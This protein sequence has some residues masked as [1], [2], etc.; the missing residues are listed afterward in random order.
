[1]RPKRPTTHRRYARLTA[2][3][4]VGIVAVLGVVW[5]APP[6]SQAAAERPGAPHVRIRQLHVRGGLPVTAERSS[7]ATRSPRAAVLRPVT[8]DAGMR[9]SMVGM[10]CDTPGTSGDVVVRVRTSG[11]GRA[12]GRWYEAALEQS[13]QAGQAGESFIEPLWTGS[14]RYVQ[15]SARAGTTRAPVKL[16]NAR[17]VAISSFADVDT[18]A[19]V[20][21]AARRASAAARVG[22][23]APAATGPAP[24]PIVTRAEWGANESWRRG[25]PSYAPVKMAFVHHTATGND[26][27]Q[28]DAPAIVRAIYR[29]HTKTLKWSDIGYDFLVDQFGTIYE[30]RYGG[31]A[32]GVVGAQVL[33][34]NTGSTGVSVIGTYTDVAPPAAALTAL[35]NL[36]A[37]KLSLGGLDPSGSVQMICGYTEKF[38]AGATVTLPVIAGHRD[39]NYTECPGDALY[40]LL[41]TVRAAVAQLVG[42]MPTMAGFTPATGPVGTVV[43][44]TGTRFTGATAVAFN[45]T[46]AA[47][48]VVSDT[49]ISAG[50]PAGATSGPIAVTAPGGTVTS[51]T[52]FTVKLVAPKLSLKL[53]GLKHGAVKLG[54]RVTAK[55]VATPTSLAGSKITLT[56]QLKKGTKWVRAK[57]ARALIAATG[58]YSWKCKPAKKGAYRMQATIAE[59]AVNAAA[60]TAWLF[61]RVK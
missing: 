17:V 58:A 48:D 9:F 21:G 19:V 10:V 20:L 22:L 47:F 18:A 26:Y 52:S 29:Y 54:K 35:E 43:T 42:P 45:G 41:P 55:G 7:S 49:R 3:L 23:A 44:I 32:E 59:T 61:F 53:K 15:V 24:P 6:A 11:D 56:A 57:A 12:W 33:G 28:A 5:A 8:L 31:V 38:K 37:W 16:E 1:M 14:A 34:F 27:T 36:L 2:V 39:A 40:A 4:L 60:K 46:A 51:A 25:S 13:E 30:G 50:V